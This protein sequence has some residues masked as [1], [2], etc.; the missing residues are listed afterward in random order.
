[1]T[2]ICEATFHEDF[3]HDTL[4]W[5]KGSDGTGRTDKFKAGVTYIIPS[6]L[7]PY[8]KELGVASA[9]GEPA[10]EKVVNKVVDLRVHDIE[11]RQEVKK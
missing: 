2:A 1:M 10:P 9:P 8:F 11:L 7:L 3:L 5:P 4:G 6:K